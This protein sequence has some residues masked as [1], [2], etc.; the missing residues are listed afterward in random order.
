MGMGIRC[1]GLSNASTGSS[2][3]F[4]ELK[5]HLGASSE[6]SKGLYNNHYSEDMN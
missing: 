1:H 4:P 6:L 2:T 3:L 5:V